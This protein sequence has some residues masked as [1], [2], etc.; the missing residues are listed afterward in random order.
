MGLVG[1]GGLEPQQ[2]TASTQAWARVKQKGFVVSP[3]RTD[4][5]VKHFLTRPRPVRRAPHPALLPSESLQRPLSYPNSLRSPCQVN[6]FRHLR[7]LEEER[8]GGKQRQLGKARGGQPT[9]GG[10]HGARDQF[11]RRK[12]KQLPSDAGIRWARQACRR[13][14]KNL[15]RQSRA[16]TKGVP[17]TAR[18]SLRAA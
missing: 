3:D 6:A 1:F 8:S 2:P 11:P 13:M 17:V 12:A 10:S 9:S 16:M 4:F 7:S 14:V 5:L 18:K 15:L